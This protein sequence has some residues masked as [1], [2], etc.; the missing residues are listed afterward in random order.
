MPSVY[1]RRKPHK[2]TAPATTAGLASGLNQYGTWARWVRTSDPRPLAPSGGE[3]F[4]VYLNPVQGDAGQEDQAWDSSGWRIKMGGS[5]A[6]SVDTRGLYIQFEPA[7]NSGARYIYPGCYWRT[8]AKDAISDVQATAINRFAWVCK[9]DVD[10][11]LGPSN[12]GTYLKR[13]DATDP[14]TQGDHGYHAHAGPFYANQWCLYVIDRRPNHRV[15][16]DDH[17]NLNDDPSWNYAAV[18]NQGFYSTD[19]GPVHYL[20]GWTRF[21]FTIWTTGTAYAGLLDDKIFT[22][23]GFDYGTATGEDDDN[24]YSLRATYD[25]VNGR[26]HLDSAGY[27]DR[28]D[29]YEVAYSTSNFWASGFSAGT[30]AGT[31][32]NPGSTYIDA[33]FDF[34]STSDT[35]IY[36]AIRRQGETPIG[37]RLYIPS[38]AEMAAMQG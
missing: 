18:G 21:Y 24:I 1:R 30:S 16:G 26:Y 37:R 35:G 4:N 19:N 15:G 29:T 31:Y 32:Q 28:W 9:M 22:I 33:H 11:P 7:G 14:D 8:F 12:V 5:A 34:P 25:P 36:V 2:V 3:A 13:H 38:Q 10:Y 27:I 20:D 23:K 17:D 6:E